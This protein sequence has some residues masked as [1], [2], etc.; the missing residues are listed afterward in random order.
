MPGC[1][2]ENT[3]GRPC[4]IASF[5]EQALAFD[6]SRGQAQHACCKGHPKS[7]A[8]MLQVSLMSSTGS[9]GGQSPAVS[10]RRTCPREAAVRVLPGHWV[11]RH[12][13]PAPCPPAARGSIVNTLVV[14]VGLAAATT[15]VQPSLAP[16]LCLH[17]RA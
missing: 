1:A 9:T 11:C 16:L 15:P 8:L 2:K 13:L 10:T 12:R 5:A 14:L 17:I 6:V 3:A 7:P 4:A